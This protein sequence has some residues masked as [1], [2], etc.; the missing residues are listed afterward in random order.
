MYFSVFAVFFVFIC[1]HGIMC[2]GV[3][4]VVVGVVGC[5]RP[6]E[7]GILG[8]R[9]DAQEEYQMSAL[10][11]WGG[12]GYWACKSCTRGVSGVCSVLEC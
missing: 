7:G 4:V 1:Y 9:E 6:W 10:C 3:V 2:W 11:T 8:V 5:R 12:G